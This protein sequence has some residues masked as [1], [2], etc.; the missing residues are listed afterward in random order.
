MPP[1]GD[2]SC[3]VCFFLKYKVLWSLII[4]L[5]GGALLSEVIGISVMEA[6]SADGTLNNLLTNSVAIFIF[7]FCLATLF[8]GWVN[9][10]GILT[11]PGKLLSYCSAK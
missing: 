6:I 10:I 3:A 8:I 11:F 5:G 7:H 2:N 4:L 9:I 1:N